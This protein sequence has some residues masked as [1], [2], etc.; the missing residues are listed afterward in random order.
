[1]A[2]RCFS[3]KSGFRVK[4]KKE[5]KFELQNIESGLFKPYL[6]YLKIMA[7]LHQKIKDT[8]ELVHIKRNAKNEFAYSL[9]RDILKTISNL[10]MEVMTLS[11]VT[12]KGSNT[13]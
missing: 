11:Q 2:W 8:E 13:S 10:S 9:N 4:V 5:S 12:L 6:E 3:Y 1:M 7:N